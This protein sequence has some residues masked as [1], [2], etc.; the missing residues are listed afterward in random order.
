MPN[1]IVSGNVDT[2]MRAAD[3]AAI[4]SAI[5]VGQTDAPTFLAITLNDTPLVRDAAGILAQRNLTNTQ[6][7]RIYNTYTDA[8]N[9]ERVSIGYSAGSFQILAE[10]LGAGTTARQLQIGTNTA[11]S[12]VFS[13]ASSGRWYINSEG[14]FRAATHNT[15][16]IGATGGV[17]CPRNVYMGSWI[18]MAVTT[19]A[20][21]PAAA[22]AGAGARMFVSD[23]LTPVF[24]RAVTGGGAVTVPVYSTG[25]AWNVG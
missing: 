19:V 25:S 11:A 6:S 8:S 4:R 10:N 21:L 20:S 22:T 3:N 12:L 18:R 14:H 9:Y 23:A 13:T 24:G 1:H 16:D 7:L 15:Y 2:M 17:N 5:G